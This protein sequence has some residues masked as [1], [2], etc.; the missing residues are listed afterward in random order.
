M[1]PGERVWSIL[2]STGRSGEAAI[3]A[4]TATLA[5]Y[6]REA[7][8]RVAPEDVGLPGGGRRHLRGLRREEVAEL[9]EISEGWYA[10]FEG[11]RATLS[12]AALERVA[13]ALR[14]DDA[15]RARLI[16]LARPDLARI[17]AHAID[18]DLS[19]AGRRFAALRDLARNVV[20]ANSID[21]AA[22]AAT[23]ALADACGPHA[24]AYARVHDRVSGELP[25]VAASGSGSGA[26][27]GHRQ[28][29]ASVAYAMR[30]FVEGQPYG[31]YDLR[32]SPCADLRTRVER[33]GIRSYHT[34]PIM[35]SGGIV[36][37]LGVARP[38]PRPPASIERQL[39]ETAAAILEISFRPR[40][41]DL[42]SA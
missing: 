40:R 33:M 28:N 4:N 25:V 39:I 32:E 41:T 42:D 14:L 29:T 22:V 13:L 21:D 37:L 19:G 12:L 8:A 38:E 24:L 17:S 16:D 30:S 3:R 27:V 2:S 1:E 26:L 7:R 5:S 11:G 31:E 10:R 23:R 18:A 6:L 20:S 36:L 35:G 34:Q 15:Q 9:A